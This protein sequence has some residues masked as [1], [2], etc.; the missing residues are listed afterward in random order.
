MTGDRT[1]HAECHTVDVAPPSSTL[2]ATKRTL[3]DTVDTMFDSTAWDDVTS[4]AVLKASGV[5]RGSMYHF[6]DDFDDLVEQVIARRYSRWVD[7]SINGLQ[8]VLDTANDASTFGTNLHTVSD[9]I[10]NLSSPAVRA[11]RAGVLLRATSSPRLRGRI[12]AEQHRLT[13]ALAAII[14]G[15]QERGWITTSVDA[16]ATAVFVQAYA[17]GRILNDVDE[18]TVGND[19]WNRVV[20]EFIDRVLLHTVD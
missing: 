12:A 13:A 16:Y 7:E 4:E 6:F 1:R 14:A 17:L 9:I 5:S 19:Q 11:E 10:H 3:L 18:V 20:G 2:H 15:G 8:W